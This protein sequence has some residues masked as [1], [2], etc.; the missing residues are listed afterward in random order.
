MILTRLTPITKISLVLIFIALTTGCATT[1]TTVGDPDPLE[2]GNR[3]FYSIND[4]LDKALLQPIAETY[5]PL[6]WHAPVSQTF[7]IILR[8]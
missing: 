1:Q 5:A 7:L 6:N 2:P 4:T 3:V 8:I